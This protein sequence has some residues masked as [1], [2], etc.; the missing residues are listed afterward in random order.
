V[1]GRVADE[2]LDDT[3]G[4]K[5]SQPQ[6]A[7]GRRRNETFLKRKNRDRRSHVSA[8]STPIDGVMT[9]NDIA[10]RKVDIDAILVLCCGI[11]DNDL[12]GRGISAAQAVGLIS[13]TAD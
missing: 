5:I 3:V 1:T 10:D 9:Y 7:T 2:G 13:V 11:D 12:T 6:L 4:R 8:R